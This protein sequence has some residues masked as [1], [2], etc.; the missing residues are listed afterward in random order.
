MNNTLKCRLFSLHTNIDA[1]P[2][3]PLTSVYSTVAYAK[4]NRTLFVGSNVSY[5]VEIEFKESV[6]GFIQWEFT[7]S[8]VSARLFVRVLVCIKS[9]FLACFE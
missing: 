9:A 5:F 7:S 8:A 1:K 4:Q 6:S 2:P 3:P